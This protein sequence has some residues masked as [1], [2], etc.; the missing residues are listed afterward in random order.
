MTTTAWKDDGGKAPWHLLPFDALREVVAVLAFGAGKYGE[1]NWEAGL[2]YSRCFSAAQRHLTAW[3]MGE[4][5]DP[6]TGCSHLAHACCCVLFLLALHWRGHGTDDRPQ[7]A[8]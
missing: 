1:R 3:W 6:E 5:A 7:G 8:A 2:S 4:N